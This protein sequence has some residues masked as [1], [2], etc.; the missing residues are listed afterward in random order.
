[1]RFGRDR[2]S[3]SLRGA[4]SPS[5]GRRPVRRVLLRRTL[6]EDVELLIGRSED[7]WPVLADPGQGEQILVNLAVNARDTMPG[8]GTTIGMTTGWSDRAHT[9]RTGRGGSRSL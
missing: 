8:G 1:M 4:G 5:G 2:R 3:A 9:I 6:G 7:L